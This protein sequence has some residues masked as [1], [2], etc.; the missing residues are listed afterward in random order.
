MIE[1][2][3]VYSEWTEKDTEIVKQYRKDVRSGKI[4]TIPLDK[5]IEMMKDD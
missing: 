2:E 5:A 3:I 1:D 4:K